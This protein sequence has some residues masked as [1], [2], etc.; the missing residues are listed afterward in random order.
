MVIINRG[1]LIVSGSVQELLRDSAVF[2]TEIRA[3]PEEEARKIL[4]RMKVMDATSESESP[5]KI[6]VNKDEIPGIVRK[7]VE[8]GIEVQSV[9]PRTSMEDY[10]LSLTEQDV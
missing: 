9:I 8:A 3:N 2:T 6:K 5:I 4:L 1:N 10:F 7:L